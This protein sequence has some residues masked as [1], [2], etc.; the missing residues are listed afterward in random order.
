MEDAQIK[1]ILRLLHMEEQHIK[2]FIS[3]NISISWSVDSLK[4][5]KDITSKTLS[6]F[7]DTTSLQRL[8]FKKFR[9]RILLNLQGLYLAFPLFLR[10]AEKNLTG[11]NQLQLLPYFV[12]LISKEGIS[13]SIW[14]M[15]YQREC[16]L[17]V[18]QDSIYK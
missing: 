1:E 6:L 11:Y 9:K 2:H 8:L 10:K 16:L 7:F 12:W 5:I 3:N 14:T 17:R 18:H 15:I 13:I 4:R